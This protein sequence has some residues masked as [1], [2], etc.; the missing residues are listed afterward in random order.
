MAHNIY[1]T[2]VVLARA[3]R[4]FIKL[5]KMVKIIVLVGSTLFVVHVVVDKIVIEK[6][7]LFKET[8]MSKL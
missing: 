5:P 3:P 4:L 2:S 7:V 8:M 1:S 6:L